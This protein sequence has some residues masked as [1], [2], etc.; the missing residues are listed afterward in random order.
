MPRDV[1]VRREG[2]HLAAETMENALLSATEN[3]SLLRPL[4]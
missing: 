1:P 3:R 4:D 2:G